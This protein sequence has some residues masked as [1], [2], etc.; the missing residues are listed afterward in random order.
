[1]ILIDAFQ[2]ALWKGL[3]CLLCGLYFLYYAI[4]E[5]EHENKLLLVLLSLGGSAIAAGILSL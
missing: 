4:F 5:V 2:D 3:V 1:V